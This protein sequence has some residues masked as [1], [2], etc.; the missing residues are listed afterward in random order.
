MLIFIVPLKSPAVSK[1]WS[2]VSQLCERCIRSICQQTVPDFHLFVVC[3]TI[4]TINFSHPS[5]TYIE[6]NFP[7][8][9]SGRTS[10]KDKWSKVKRGLIAARHLAPAHFM[11][12]DA[13]DCVHRDLASLVKSVS[14]NQGWI[15]NTGYIYDEGSNWLYKKKYFDQVCGSSSIV[16]CELKNLPLEMSDRSED[17][18]M[19]NCGHKG[20]SNYFIQ[21]GTPLRLLPFIGSIYITETGENDSQNSVSKWRGT[22]ILTK[23]ILNL[24][25]LTKSIRLKYGLYQL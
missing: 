5:I 9:G 4:P 17:L 23:K 1:D 2:K 20:I 24:R 21:R 19:L 6:E 25:L 14:N 16:K 12:V 13:D 3:N 15:F 18:F 11:V 8:P 7:L 22:K 10:M